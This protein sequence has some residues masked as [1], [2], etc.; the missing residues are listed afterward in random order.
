MALTTLT[1]EIRTDFD[2][3]RK[4]DALREAAKNAARTLTGVAI[5]LQERQIPEVHLYE[6]T[7]E[8]SSVVELNE[9]EEAAE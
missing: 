6:N 1:L 5:M 7:N 3:P 8:G 9:I 2:D 4:H